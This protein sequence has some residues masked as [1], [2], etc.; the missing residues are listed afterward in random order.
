MGVVV[1]LVNVEVVVL[2]LVW[3]LVVVVFGFSV[4]CLYVFVVVVCLVCSLCF[5]ECWRLLWG[6]FFVCGRSSFGGIDF[7]GWIFFVDLLIYNLNLEE[8]RKI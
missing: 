2:V 8:R 5:L 6:V 4:Y 3:E 1:F 7:G